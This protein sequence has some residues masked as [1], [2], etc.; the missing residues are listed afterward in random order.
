MEIR[1]YAIGE[2]QAL[3]QLFYETVHQI[4]IRDY[5]QAQVE[6]WAPADYDLEAWVE[7]L[8]RSSPW[9]AVEDN[10]L[11]GFAEMDSAG[12]IDCFY[13]QHARLGRQVGSALMQ[14]LQ[15][16]ALRL[17]LA[18]LEVEASVTARGFFQHKGFVLVRRQQV[19]RRG[20]SLINYLMRK[21]IG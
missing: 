11:L 4:N 5:S 3:R 15:Y 2:E 17:G 13:V 12:R 18:R 14:K 7:R 20:Q 16:Q 19:E 8:K 9:V 6:A 1:R 10:D 21:S